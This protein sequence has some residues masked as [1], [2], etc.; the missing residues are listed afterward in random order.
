V[1]QRFHMNL[2]RHPCESRDEVKEILILIEFMEIELFLRGLA[3]DVD[4][5]KELWSLTP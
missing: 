3:R 5:N 1:W 4:C 2:R